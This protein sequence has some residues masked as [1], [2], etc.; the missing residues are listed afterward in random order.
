[1]AFDLSTVLADLQNPGVQTAINVG[2]GLIPNPAAQGAASAAVA[3]LPSAAALIAGFTSGQ[4]TA[5]QVQAEWT[6]NQALYQQG[7]KD[8]DAADPAKP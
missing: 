6:R 4:L 2:I 3:L 1:M 7:R 8:W 5:D